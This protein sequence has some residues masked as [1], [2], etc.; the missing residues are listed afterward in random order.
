MPDLAMYSALAIIALAACL[1]TAKALK[2]VRAK[3]ALVAHRQELERRLSTLH[4][5][6]A[7]DNDIVVR[8]EAR[9]AQIDEGLRTVD[10]GPPAVSSASRE[11]ALGVS[12]LR[13][14]AVLGVSRSIRLQAEAKVTDERPSAPDVWVDQ[15]KKD[16]HGKALWAHYYE[17]QSIP[18]VLE[19]TC[20]FEPDSARGGPCVATVFVCL[21]F[22][23]FDRLCE[24]SSHYDY[25]RGIAT[26][27]AVLTVRCERKDA[28]DRA[29]FEAKCWALASLRR[30]TTVFDG[31]APTI[32]YFEARK[33]R[34]YHEAGIHQTA[35]EIKQVDAK[36]VALQSWRMF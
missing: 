31:S 10:R 25:R 15:T 14:D 32:E 16:K 5:A 4:E 35:I 1:L 33:Y 34:G 3:Q 20:A 30:S 17:I 36:L 18:V 7:L 26:W 6:W 8:H 29:A 13:L 27:R 11:R 22:V 24:L 21:L 12:N 28:E 23:S 19:M 2:Q 9:F